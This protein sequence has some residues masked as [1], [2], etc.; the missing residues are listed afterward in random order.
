MQPYRPQS[1]SPQATA[2][3]FAARSP[4]A[5]SVRAFLEQNGVRVE[6]W[7]LRTWDVTELTLLALH[8]HPD[9]EAARANVAVFQAAL[10][11]AAIPAAPSATPQ[12]ERHSRADA[13]QSQWTYGMTLEVPLSAPE[14]GAARMEQARSRLD[15]AQVTADA[16]AW[17]VAS[18]LRR[19]LVEAFVA[20]KEL[21]LAERERQ[22]AAA[23]A[24]AAQRRLDAGAGTAA[25]VTEARRKLDQASLALDRARARAD[26][27]RVLLAEAVGLPADA[28][29]GLVL[30]DAG[31]ESLPA[32][33]ESVAARD[34]ALQRRADLRLALLSYE[35]ADSALKLAVA[36][37]YPDLKITPGYLW[38]QGDNIW[39]LALTVPLQLLQDRSAPVREAEARRDLEARNFLALQ[40]RTITRLEAVL[41]DYR[42]GISALATVQAL[43]QAARE[44]ATRAER[45]LAAGA[46]DRAETLAADAALVGA[47]RERLIAAATAQRALLDLEDAMQ[48]RL[49][50][51]GADPRL[52]ALAGTG[53]ASW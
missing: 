3:Q 15:S 52:P 17:Q 22:I 6:Q 51:S 42:A 32:P 40:A 49:A 19:Q 21:E 8:F 1:L 23:E 33:P 2:E 7:P 48:M 31:M 28:V 37:Q 11:A 4:H 25:A 12:L 27:S 47:E 53:R 45:A 29:R 26:R 46:A 50:G 34:A 16:T 36:N 39:L 20:D 9:L 5:P 38:D 41:T 14:K 18:L 13:G 10:D 43:E 30:S 44:H 35:A 24:G